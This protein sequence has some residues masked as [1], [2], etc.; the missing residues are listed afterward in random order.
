MTTQHNQTES[1]L[2][3]HSFEKII[4]SDLQ[5]EIGEAV[6]DHDVYSNAAASE[7]TTANAA[8]NQFGKQFADKFRDTDAPR[9]TQTLNST[10][11]EFPQKKTMKN[12]PEWRDE[13]KN[14]VE[15]R[16]QGKSVDSSETSQKQSV[17]SKELAL[18]QSEPGLVINLKPRLGDQKTPKDFAANALRRIEESRQRF[19]GEFDDEP[20]TGYEATAPQH[21]APPLALVPN[22]GAAQ[23]AGGKRKV[24]PMIEDES[25]AASENQ[26]IGDFARS[27][28][29]AVLRSEQGRPIHYVAANQTATA[30]KGF[31]EDF[32][33][34]SESERFDDLESDESIAAAQSS[35]RRISAAKA[36]S[37]QQPTARAANAQRGNRGKQLN[38]D[39][40][41]LGKRFIAAAADFTLC[42]FTTVA[43]IYAFGLW[44]TMISGANAALWQPILLFA[45][46][47]FLYLTT[48]LVLSGTT[49]GARLFSLST[50]AAE[51]GFIPALPQAAART[52]LYLL[53]LLTGGIGLITVFFSSERRALHDLIAGTVVVSDE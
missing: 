12:V 32:S 11:L 24:L 45:V 27:S 44:R 5:L 51:D 4:T 26:T 13:I 16:K 17:Q 47:M 6:H 2:K 14:R 7:N 18:A 33:R 1:K 49:L 37:E 43:V 50:V 53:V 29:S 31:V 20:E 28:D 41:P 19:Y 48:A 39:F 42:A 10:L 25:A 30:K 21:E 52:A 38:E 34:E 36:L 40:A 15:L 3:I 22:T 8:A 35:V 23:P 46:I 9:K